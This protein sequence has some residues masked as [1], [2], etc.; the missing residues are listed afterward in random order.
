[1]TTSDV[2]LAAP[3]PPGARVL[4][5]RLD[6][7][8]VLL[9]HISPYGGSE[10]RTAVLKA[11]HHT[12]GGSDEG[13]AMADEWCREVGNYPGPERF[14]EI[15]RSI[16]HDPDEADGF[17]R[18]CM[19]AED[20]G[21][22]WQTL[23]G[24]TEPGFEVCDYS[25]IEIAETPPAPAT[26]SSI[27]LDRYSLT[28]RRE[29]VERTAVDQVHVLGR[30][31]LAGQVTA[32][33]GQ[34]AIGKSLITTSLL[35]K[36]CVEGCIDPRKCYYLDFDTDPNGLLQKIDFARAH[37]FHVLSDGFLN[38][39]SRKFLE[40]LEDLIRSGSAVGVTIVLDTAKQHVSLM[41]KERLAA[42]ASRLRSCSKAGGTVIVLAHVN[43]N[44][45]ANGKPVYAGVTDLVEQIDAYYILSEVGVDAA[46]QT[47]TV[48]FENG[49]SRGPIARRVSFRYSVAEGLSYA[50][51]LDSVVEVEETDLPEMQRAAQVRTDAV[52]ID[53]VAACIAAGVV[54]KMDLVSAAAERSGL[55]KRTVLEVLER[56]TGRDPAVHRWAF[57]VHARGEKRYALLDCSASGG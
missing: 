39:S 25:V 54:A 38:F 11:V 15:W 35:G 13:L 43:K 33:F 45:G 3:V 56:Y 21:F 24:D 16:K 1:M 30:L 29:E 41:D 52:L 55:S 44:V 50:E 51:L 46:T 48:L 36:A 18:L 37:G 12:T 6:R 7:V 5:P 2:G 20:H 53:A 19:L 10:Q 26:A 14:A 22:D 57:T 27:A 17:G 47:R 49:K 4:N 28:F 32:I 8:R 42:F 31:A 23:C 40:E 34:P 9:R